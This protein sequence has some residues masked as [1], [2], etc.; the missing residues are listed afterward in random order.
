MPPRPAC[1]ECARGRSRMSG[2]ARPSC[3]SAATGWW[4]WPSTAAAPVPGWALRPG[5]PWGYDR[6]DACGPSVGSACAKERVERW[7]M[8]ATGALVGGIERAPRMIP[9]PESPKDGLS[10][11]P[12]DERLLE[13]VAAGG[14]ESFAAVYD[15]FSRLVYALARKMLGDPQA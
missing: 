2:P 9:V 12:Q 1:R 13:R 14:V 15:R 4:K 11:I 6:H 8:L 3:W 5:W 7:S 10:G